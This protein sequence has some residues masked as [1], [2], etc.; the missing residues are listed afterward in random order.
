MMNTKT[1]KIQKVD[2]LQETLDKLEHYAEF[3]FEDEEEFE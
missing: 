3:V 2:R 1:K